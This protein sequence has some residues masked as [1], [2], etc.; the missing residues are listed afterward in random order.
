M[1]WDST[2]LLNGGI[3]P[4]INQP[5]AELSL[6]EDGEVW[7]KGGACYSSARTLAT[8]S[9]TIPQISIANT[10]EYSFA[11][12]IKVESVIETMSLFEFKGG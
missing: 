3:A 9:I 6:C 1:Q 10:G 5:N 7:S 2:K 11:V 12:W 8:K 4:S